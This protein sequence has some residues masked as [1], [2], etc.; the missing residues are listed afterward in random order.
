MQGI[1]SITR[2]SV[3]INFVGMLLRATEVQSYILIISFVCRWISF[4]KS[5]HI[6]SYI[7]TKQIESFVWKYHLRKIY[8]TIAS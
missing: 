6:A 3:E 5:D 8:P 2:I 4:P 7:A 1:P